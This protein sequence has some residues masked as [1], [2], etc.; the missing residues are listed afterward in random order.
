MLRILV[1][2]TFS[3]FVDKIPESAVS[4][5]MQVERALINSQKQKWISVLF[6]GS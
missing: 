4:V 6:P 1:L 5:A 3:T 2:N